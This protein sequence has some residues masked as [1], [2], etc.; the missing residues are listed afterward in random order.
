MLKSIPTSDGCAMGS[1]RPSVISREITELCGWRVPTV[2]EFTLFLMPVLFGDIAGI[3]Y[4]T[5]L[6]QDFTDRN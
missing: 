6:C 5:S 2:Q 4:F 1:A 3:P